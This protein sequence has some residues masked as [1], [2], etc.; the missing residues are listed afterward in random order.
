[1]GFRRATLSD[2]A[3]VLKLADEFFSVYQSKVSYDPGFFIPFVRDN[4]DDEDFLVL[5]LD[6]A[7]GMLIGAITEPVF[8]DVK[9][10]KEILWYTR[11]GARGHGM[12]LFREFER[13][14]ARRGAIE[15][16][17]SIREP[18]PVMHRLGFVP[19]DVAYTKRLRSLGHDNGAASSIH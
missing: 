8:A 16:Y 4:L 6:D 18:H 13:W 5:L 12:Q 7:E 1:M 10:A 14:S 2:M 3:T 11:P 19:V 17:C 15:L 9:V